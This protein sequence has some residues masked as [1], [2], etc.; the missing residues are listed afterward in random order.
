VYVASGTGGLLALD[1]NTGEQR[2]A[3]ELD[4]YAEGVVLTGGLALVASRDAPDA[5][6]AVTAFANAGP[7]ATSSTAPVSGPA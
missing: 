6:G 3:R 1:A 2:W 7:Y 5:A 4:G